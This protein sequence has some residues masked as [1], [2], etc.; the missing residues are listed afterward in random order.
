MVLLKTEGQGN[1]FSSNSIGNRF[2]ARK[3]S[4][5][6]VKR[7]IRTHLGEIERFFPR[8]H[9]PDPKNSHHTAARLRCLYGLVDSDFENVVYPRFSTML[10]TKIAKIF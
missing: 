8:G 7:R 5:Y 10:N 3:N 9:L 1:F 6:K 4:R 2:P